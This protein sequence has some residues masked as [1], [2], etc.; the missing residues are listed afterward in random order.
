MSYSAHP[1]SFIHPFK[2]QHYYMSKFKILVVEDQP[3]MRQALSGILTSV[4]YEVTEAV[5]GEEALT[6]A[7]TVPDAVTINFELPDTD[8]LTLAER[9]R[10]M[11]GFE[12]TPLILITSRQLPGNCSETPLPW[13]NGY[14]NKED[15]IDHLLPCIEH[16]IGD[17]VT[18]PDNLR[19]LQ[20][21]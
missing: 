10:G 1:F 4:G 12:S 8:G 11:P 3:L 2:G 19:D 7:Q 14:I 5:N 9:L 15:L 6:H 21:Q 17:R 16:H 13:V 18:R 20:S